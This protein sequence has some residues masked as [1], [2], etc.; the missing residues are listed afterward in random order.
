MK[1]IVRIISRLN[2]G[3]PAIH[4]ILLSEE[5][6]KGG[7]RDILVCGRVSES[8]GDMGYFARER[9]VD[10]LVIPELK[11]DISLADDLKAFCKI[12]SIIKRE[13]PDIVH[14]HA[15]KAGTLGRLAALLCGVPVKMHTFHGH[16]F[17]GY[18]SPFK[19]K[20]FLAIER[21]LALFTDRVI[22][23]SE[24]VRHE[25]ADKLKVAHPSKCVIVP[26]GLELGKFFDCEKERGKF[27]N[28]LGLSGATLLVGIVGRLV[29]IKN[30]EMFLNAAKKILEMKPSPDIR[31][32]VVG[33]GELKGHLE[34]YAA[35]LGL[36][37]HVI[38][39]GWRK[40]LAG[41]YADLDIVALTSLNEGTPVSLIEAMASGR[42]V[43]ST[44]VGGVQD[45]VTEGLNGYLVPSQDTSVFVQRLSMLMTDG[46]KRRQ[47]GL[48][49]REKVGHKFSKERLVRDMKSLY[50][51]CLKSK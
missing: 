46:P 24:A 45:L 33:D 14:T 42:P 28:E 51:E 49:G 15:A 12:Y 48:C 8:E 30:H 29:P 47:F 41:V 9:N 36:G 35:R 5:L 23:V 10:P 40:D 27:R 19:A 26:L 3:G 39:T 7:Y 38:F 20:V 37:S 18:F 17:D 50:A 21:F 16:I 25:I 34:S 4:T 11:R 31:F 22:T 32:I 44:K 43:I 6:N 13:K 2:V 1:K